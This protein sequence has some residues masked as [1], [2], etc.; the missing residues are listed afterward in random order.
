MRKDRG[1]LFI[2]AVGLTVVLAGGPAGAQGASLG[3]A[4]AQPSSTALPADGAPAM[5]RKESVQDIVVTAQRF[6]ERLQRVP[7]AVSAATGEQLQQAGVTNIAQF[8]GR[9]PGLTITQNVGIINLYIRGIGSSF[10]TLG[11]DSSVSLYEDGIYV[12]RP[13][14]QSTAFMDV[15]RIEVLRGPQGTLYG[16]NATGGAINIISRR[17]TDQ[18]AVNAD[19]TG[20]N[21]GYGHFEGGIGGP[22]AGDVIK[23]RVAVIA[24]RRNGYGENLVTGNDIDNLREFGGRAMFEVQPAPAFSYLVQGEYYRR[25]DRSNPEHYLGPAR[26]DVVPTGIALGGYVPADGRDIASES[27]PRFRNRVYSFTG[28]GSWTASDALNLKLI[29]GY[30]N[31]NFFLSTDADTTSVPVL[32][33][34]YSERAHQFSQDLQGTYKAGPITAIAGATYFSETTSGYSRV[35]LLFLGPNAFA[36]SGPGI[37]KTRAYAFYGQLGYALTDRLTITG[38]ARFSHEHRT[39]SGTSGGLPVPTREVTFHAVTPKVV[40]DYK[41]DENNMLYALAGKGFKSGLILIGSANPPV[42]PE[43]IWDYEVGYKGRLLNGALQFNL[44]AF[45]YNYRNVQVTRFLNNVGVTENAKGATVKGIEAEAT[46][47]PWKGGRISLTGSYLDSRF[48]QF[49]TQDSIR[50]ELGVINVKGN[51]LP[52]APEF[53]ATVDAEQHA[54]LSNGQALVFGGDVRY[55]TRRYDDAF[56]IRSRGQGAYAIVDGRIT[57]LPNTHLSLALWMRNAAGATVKTAVLGG[58]QAAGF[59]LIGVFNEPRTFGA[60]L[61]YRI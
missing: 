27:D 43:T 10:L 15:E 6:S 17:P 56:Q 53:T 33:I 42:A 39:G 59:P 16:R 20:G 44:S 50:P 48:K 28:T 30:R 51:R 47:I 18:L 22:I 58:A 24:S 29:T 54:E 26:L 13:R 40:V 31:S 3:Q 57:Y 41:L 2:S 36:G 35:G 23:G 34:A 25:H 38:S 11:A 5:L 60:T 55:T 45:Y 9:V 12:S 37:G 21:Y 7:L 61:S 32:G 8:S 52:F 49:L 4:A 14:S 46:A 1:F 19:L